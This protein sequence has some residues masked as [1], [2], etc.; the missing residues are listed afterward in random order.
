MQNLKLPHIPNSKKSSNA[1]DQLFNKENSFKLFSFD[2][3][4][5]SV[6]KRSKRLESNW[7][8]SQDASEFSHWP[9]LSQ[10]RNKG[11]LNIKLVDLRQNSN[12]FYLSPQPT[13]KNIF[14]S[15]TQICNKTT[16]RDF[17]ETLKE[18]FFKNHPM[19]YKKFWNTLR[20]TIRTMNS[21]IQTKAAI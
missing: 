2:E 7:L 10:F 13:S 19:R 3:K 15:A 12:L 18:E 6:P 5:F 17:E 21:V 8:L 1:L 20:K 9:K 14:T 11:K 16:I 4:R